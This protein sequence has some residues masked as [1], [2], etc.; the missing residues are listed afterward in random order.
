[1][2]TQNTPTVVSSSIDELFTLVLVDGLSVQSA[3]KTIKYRTIKLRETNVADERIAQKWAERVAM[4]NGVHK[5]VVSDADFRYCLT[6]RHIE[7]FHCDGMSIP[8][9]MVDMALTDKLSSHDFGLI[10]ARVFL[11]TL[12]AEVRYGNM[13]QAEFDR[14]MEGGSPKATTS[15]QRTGQTSELGQAAAQSESG[16]ALL[17]D[18]TGAATAGTPAGDAR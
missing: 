10:E 4:I 1:M 9:A 8:Q 12:A 2:S 3:G 17:A 11:I 7:S 16:P 15:P 13:T 6:T 14:V 5:L 18:F